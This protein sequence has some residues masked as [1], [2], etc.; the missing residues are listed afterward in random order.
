V[1]RAIILDAKEVSWLL[2]YL[3]KWPSKYLVG[4]LLLCKSFT[5]SL[6]RN[7]TQRR[8][9]AVPDFGLGYYALIAGVEGKLNTIESLSFTSGS[10]ESAKPVNI[11]PG[12]RFVGVNTALLVL[13]RPILVLNCKGLSFKLVLLRHK[14]L[15]IR[16]VIVVAVS[17]KCY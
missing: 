7:E 15:T 9:K 4:V 16:S 13:L 12:N 14:G 2:K 3:L 6:V 5:F 10:E 11:S 8:F 1:N 17:S